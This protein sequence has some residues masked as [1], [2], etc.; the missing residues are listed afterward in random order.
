MDSLTKHLELQNFDDEKLKNDGYEDIS[1]TCQ[2]LF[3]NSLKAVECLYKN[4]FINSDLDKN[5]SNLEIDEEKL[6]SENVDEENINLLTNKLML[7]LKVEIGLLKMNKIREHLISIFSK[8]YELSNADNC[9]SKS[10]KLKESIKDFKKVSSIVEQYQN[11]SSFFVLQHVA[12]LKESSK[13][14]SILMQLFTELCEKGFCSPAE[15][16]DSGEGGEGA[17]EFEDIEGG[18]IGEGQGIKDVSDEIEFEE[19]V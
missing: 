6:K 5:I 11:L 4:N 10:L 14:C 12:A 9:L 2:S 13:M 17:T 8:F 1:K 3:N 19:Q 15:L 16:Q 7:K 18:G